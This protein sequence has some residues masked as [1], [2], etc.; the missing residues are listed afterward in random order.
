MCCQVSSVV[1]PV[2]R[3]KKH[4]IVDLTVPIY[5]SRF[6]EQVVYIKFNSTSVISRKLIQ[7]FASV[8]L[9]ARLSLQVMR[10][11]QNSCSSLLSRSSL[12]SYYLSR[13]TSLHSVVCANSKSS[14]SIREKASYRIL[15]V[16]IA[17]L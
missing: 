15:Y 6:P 3:K 10:L 8:L 5:K 16:Q 14:R 2:I 11:V 1:L 13:Y 12:K 7:N 17:L 4:G 9:S